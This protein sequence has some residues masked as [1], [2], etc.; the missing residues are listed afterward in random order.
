VELVKDLSSQPQF[1][2][3]PERAGFKEI[4][5]PL[6]LAAQRTLCERLAKRVKVLHEKSWTELE[7]EEDA[8][9]GPQTIVGNPHPTDY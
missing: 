1:E 4:R 8:E 9:V 5:P 2:L 3:D 6:S 7:P